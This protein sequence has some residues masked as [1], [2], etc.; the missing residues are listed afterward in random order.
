MII[1]K[2]AEEQI[3]N[4]GVFEYDTLK[5]SNILDVSE[6]EIIKEM[7][8]TSSDFYKLYQKGVDMADYVIDLKLFDMAKSGDIKALDKLDFRKRLRLDALKKK[9]QIIFSTI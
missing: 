8:N 1:A 6:H 2:E 5:M 4:F 7:K 3:V 9:K